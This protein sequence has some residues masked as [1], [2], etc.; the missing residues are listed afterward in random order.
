MGG[1]G[2]Y[3][4]PK[5]RQGNIVWCLVYHDDRFGDNEEQQQDYKIIDGKVLPAMDNMMGGVLWLYDINPTVCI[6]SNNLMIS[7]SQLS[8]HFSSLL[9]SQHTTT[10]NYTQN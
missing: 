9:Q 1:G 2:W 8:T 10:N 3:Y 7:F 6:V 4:V 5:V